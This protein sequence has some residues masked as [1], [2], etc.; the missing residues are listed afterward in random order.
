MDEL[1]KNDLLKKLYLLQKDKDFKS[2][3]EKNNSVNEELMEVINQII[4]FY[5]ENKSKNRDSLIYLRNMLNYFIKTAR[6]RYDEEAK[7]KRLNNVIEN[8]GG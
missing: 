2:K 3:I 8:I 7:V 5:V 6:V 4:I 1:M